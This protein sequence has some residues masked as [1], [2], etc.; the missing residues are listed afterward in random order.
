[1][2]PIEITGLDHLEGK[3]VTF[4]QNDQVVT[5]LPVEGG[6]VS[7]PTPR[8]GGEYGVYFSGRLRI[9]LPYTAEIETLDLEFP[10]ADGTMQTRRRKMAKVTVR[11]RDTQGGRLGDS[12]DSKTYP[13]TPDRSEDDTH[14]PF[15][16]D[17]EMSGGSWNKD[18]RVYIIQDQPLPMTVLAI[19]P[20]M[21]VG[22]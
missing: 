21:E 1:M 3:E 6:K 15:T 11:F 8:P 12:S 19:I 13:F 14:A 5:S 4:T 18:G 2:N 16:G 9:G 7:L 17:K 22:E 10:L 20:E